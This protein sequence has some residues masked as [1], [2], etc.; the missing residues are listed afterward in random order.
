LIDKKGT[1]VYANR[2]FQLKDEVWQDLF[3]AV[4]ALPD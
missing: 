2:S 1:L 3:K 4:E